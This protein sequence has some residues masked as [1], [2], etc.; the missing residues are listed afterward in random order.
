MSHAIYLGRELEKAKV[1]LHTGVPYIQDEDI[2]LG[3]ITQ[4]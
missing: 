1:A 4:Q 2:E 3:D